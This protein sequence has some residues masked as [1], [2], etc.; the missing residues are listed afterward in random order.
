MTKPSQLTDAQS[1]YQSNEALFMRL[2]VQENQTH[3]EETQQKID[4]IITQ[5][6]R[7][8]AP[9][10]HL[11]R[12]HD[13]WFASE[14]ILLYTKTLQKHLKEKTHDPNTFR[15]IYYNLQELLVRANQYVNPVSEIPI[16]T[17]DICHN[18]QAPS[19]L[20]PYLL[21]ILTED[22]DSLTIKEALQTLRRMMVKAIQ[23]ME[24]QSINANNNDN[25]YAYLYDKLVANLSTIT[26]LSLSP[27]LDTESIEA[28]ILRMQDIYNNLCKLSYIKIY[29][30][31]KEP[32]NLF[33]F[34]NTY[35]PVAHCKNCG[36]MHNEIHLEND[37]SAPTVPVKLAKLSHKQESFCPT[38]MSD[39]MV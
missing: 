23:H 25:N 1:F 37:A 33:L 15:R 18:R 32:Y 20:F 17:F 36:S 26:H 5:H 19:H 16:F 6:I 8:K 4:K 10:N 2:N 28:L 39:N 30:P 24:K 12:W 27:I 3:A 35:E 7:E 38:C 29:P 13:Y 22:C 34:T 14:Q 11:H 31:N 21:P 9:V